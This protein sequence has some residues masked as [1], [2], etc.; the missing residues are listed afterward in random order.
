MKTLTQ[1]QTEAHERVLKAI[2]GPIGDYGEVD[3]TI[4]DVISTAYL[5]GKE[6]AVE[7]I[8]L[9]VIHSGMSE[10]HDGEEPTGDWIY[11]LPESVLEQAKSL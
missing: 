6:S 11:D 1:I 10:R 2:G 9:Q 7:Y 4:N 5:A 3:N 8:K